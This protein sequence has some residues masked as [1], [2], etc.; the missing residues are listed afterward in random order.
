MDSLSQTDHD[1]LKWKSNWYI[2]MYLREFG[3]AVAWGYGNAEQSESSN[4]VEIGIDFDA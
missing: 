4:L 3:A 2:V 1:T